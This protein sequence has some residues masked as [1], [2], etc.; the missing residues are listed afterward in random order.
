MLRAVSNGRCDV[1]SWRL[2]RGSLLTALA[3][4][5]ALGCSDATSS[6]T[7]KV[8]LLLKDA[9]GDI[10]AAVVTISE[11]DLQG[12]GGSTVLMSTPT[13]TDLT[14]LAS[15][16]ASLVQNAVVPAGTYTQLR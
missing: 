12:S 16:T 10:K 8:S 9:P 15:T 2:T 13:T 3:V 1:I 14:T 5:G 6:G 11:V 4:A 7:G